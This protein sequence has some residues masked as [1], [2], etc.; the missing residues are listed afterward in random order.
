MPIQNLTY[1]AA[2]AREGHFGRAAEACHVTQP[3]LSNGIRRLEE[4]LG[5][6][7]VRRGHRYEG[8]TARGRAAS[9]LGAPDPRR[10]G[11][12]CGWTSRRCAR[13]W[14]AACGSA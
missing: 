10:R 9:E 1:L 7:L 2:V 6:A 5:V 12:A 14:P 8:L 11:R 4:E 13:A 3:T